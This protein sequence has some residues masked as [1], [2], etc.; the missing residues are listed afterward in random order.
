MFSAEHLAALTDR[1][2]T[3]VVTFVP[4]VIV[5][6][7]ILALAG[8]V[9]RRVA[10]GAATLLGRSNHLDP[11]IRYVATDFIRYGVIILALLLAL[12]QIGVQTTSLFAI[13]GAA[14]LAIGLALQG[15]LSNIAAGIMLLW[16]RPFHIG[17]FIEVNNVPGLAGAVRQIGLF[18]CQL[19]AFDGLFLFVPNSALWNVPLRNYSRNAGRLISFAITIP[20]HE[21]ADGARRKL[22]DMAAADPRI[23]KTPAPRVFVDRVSAD[24]CLLTFRVWAAPHHIGALQRDLVEAI[25]A[26]LADVNGEAGRIQVVRTVPP[27]SDPTRL[28]EPEGT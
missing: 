1:L 27:D 2:W 3:L 20:G 23:A 11:T 12:E 25:E 5:A 16:L 9:A 10:R 18:T 26:V 19:E 8:I 15:T 13:L 4:R 17:D 28:I 24:G 22:V 21:A 7:V 14:G 6:I